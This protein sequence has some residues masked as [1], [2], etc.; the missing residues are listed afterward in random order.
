MKIIKNL[1]K[2]RTGHKE[3]IVLDTFSIEHSND[4]TYHLVKNGETICGESAKLGFFTPIY[5]TN[6]SPKLIKNKWNDSYLLE[7][8]TS[9]LNKNKCDICNM[10][11]IF[12]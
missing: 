9:P 8:E 2:F 1:F 6:T 11:S 4:K 12:M 3:K 5:V 7:P 10:L